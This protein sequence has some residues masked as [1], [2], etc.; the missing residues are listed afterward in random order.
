MQELP[1]AARPDLFGQLAATDPYQRRSRRLFERGQ[2][3]EVSGNEADLQVGTDA[4]GN[5]LVLKQ[6]PMVSGYV[7]G[8]GDWVAIHYE[9][10]H[11]GAP[12]VTGPSMAGEASTDPA[13][14][15][16]FSVSPSAPPDPAT[17]TVY[18]DESQGL[19]RGW[20]GA[21]W[22]DIT[23]K[24]HNTLPDL[25]GGAP[26]AYYHVTAAQWDGLHGRQH[27]L[28][29]EDH[30]DTAASAVAAGALIYG[31]A[32]PKWA[33]LAHPGAQGRILGTA[34]DDTLGWRNDLF[35]QDANPQQFRVLSAGAAALSQ[36]DVDP[37]TKLATDAAAL[38]LFRN[39]NASGTR[40]I[41]LYKGDN[42]AALLWRFSLGE[43]FFQGY[44]GLVANDR[45]WRLRRSSGAAGNIYL[46]S[47]GV[48]A[49][50]DAGGH[51][52]WNYDGMPD[53]HFCFGDGDSVVQSH[54]RGSDGSY[55]LGAVGATMG[56]IKAA[57]GMDIAYD[58]TNY[59]EFRN[60]VA[61]WRFLTG[62]WSYKISG[63]ELSPY[64]N[65]EQYL[66]NGSN[67]WLGIYSQYVYLGSGAYWSGLTANEARLY[68]AGSLSARF[69]TH[70]RG[71]AIVG[72]G[73][74]LYTGTDGWAIDYRDN[75]GG[76]TIGFFMMN[77]G[78]TAADACALMLQTG[79][80]NADAFTRYRVSGPI[81]W[82]SGIDASDGNRYVWS[83]G[84]T[85]GSNN[86]AWL[87]A[88]GHFWLYPNAVALGLADGE[89]R[90]DTTR[91]ATV[92]RMGNMVGAFS[93]VI[94]QQREVKAGDRITAKAE[95]TFDSSDDVPIQPE[96]W[97]VGKSIRL[98]AWG[99]HGFALGTPLDQATIRVYLGAL[100][101]LERT[102][103]GE[104][105][106]ARYAKWAVKIVLRC[107]A[108]GA[109]GTLEMDTEWKP[110]AYV[111][112]DP[113]TAPTLNVIT[114]PDTTDVYGAPISRAL[115]AANTLHITVQRNAISALSGYSSMRHYLV[116]ELP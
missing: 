19:W 90:N 91:L 100:K 10:G 4:R 65:L 101:I 113:E 110:T 66:G 11:S 46:D 70:N 78:N 26:N 88:N 27:N 80:A 106:S 8:V 44:G 55:I 34:G 53:R 95:T 64:R 2:V 47:Y 50:Q 61:Y 72:L 99:I 67:Y 37:L 71:F 24:L 30:S 3:V 40:Y 41:E 97:A 42:T 12:C 16:V 45:Y 22:V 68:I 73:H 18:F 116:E 14:I 6:V 83:Y 21:Q 63:S 5:A 20:D 32:T 59:L 98:T 36:W 69:A 104:Q 96:D 89:L 60:D 93:R 1:L 109:G 38:R 76:G 74:G 33:A 82:C 102:L 94:A 51:F 17:S 39:V 79:A 108:T 28:L 92:S 49:P 114:G 111:G 105:Y 57:L 23:G 56:L 115:N 112:T 52:Y 75:G 35:L 13:G 9:A 58:G 81:D 29:S 54:V 87:D 103:S 43:G 62:S 86:R 7:P 85:P 31:N 107:T 84:T 48:E 77:S 25:Q 15:G